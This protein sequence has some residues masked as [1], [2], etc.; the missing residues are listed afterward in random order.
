MKSLALSN[1]GMDREARYLEGA[2]TE[3][4]DAVRTGPLPGTLVSFARFV[5]F[6]GGVGVASSFAVAP[7]AGLMPWTAAN[8]LITVASTVLCTELHARFTFGARQRA[9]RRQHWQSA[10]SAAAAYVVTTVAVL[11]LHA[12]RPA[13]GTLSEQAVYLCASGLAGTGRFLVLR[14][15][16]FATGR[17]RAAEQAESSATI[18]RPNVTVPRSLPAPALPL[19]LPLPAAMGQPAPLPA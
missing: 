15:Y 5:F 11:I 4:G 17:N 7:I 16:V 19:D 2:E 13:A 10:G 3:R 14:L 6:G 1:P 9:G 8:A 18:Q 12:V